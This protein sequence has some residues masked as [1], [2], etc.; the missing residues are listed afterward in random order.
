MIRDMIA[1]GD[2]ARSEI[3]L[4]EALERALIRLRSFGATFAGGEDIS[5][6][7]SLSSGYDRFK[8]WESMWKS[9]A[10]ANAL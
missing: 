10:A 6:A 5:A 1:A 2:S 8:H 9:G 3:L 7:G 4:I